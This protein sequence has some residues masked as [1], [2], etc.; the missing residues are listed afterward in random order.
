CGCGGSSCEIRW[1][2]VLGAAAGQCLRSIV[3]F[4]SS[5][6]LLWHPHRSAYF[7]PSVAT[8]VDL[9]LTFQYWGRFRLKRRTR[10]G[11]QPALGSSFAG[12]RP[13][14]STPQPSRRVAL[15]IA[16]S[17]GAAVAAAIQTST[18]GKSV[19]MIERR[20]AGR[21]CVNTGCVTSKALLAAAEARHGAADAARYPGITATAGPVDMPAVIAGKGALV[22]QMRSD[23]YLDLI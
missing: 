5:H 2:V 6:R 9:S 16:G 7:A 13:R 1:L 3:G 22:E 23:K 19:V 12:G 20:A 15:P 18:L 14:I 10:D 11:Q 21:T 4:L 8:D 17:R